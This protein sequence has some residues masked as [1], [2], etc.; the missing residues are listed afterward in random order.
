MELVSTSHQSQVAPVGFADVAGKAQQRK[1]FGS[2]FKLR[3]EQVRERSAYAGHHKALKRGETWTQNADGNLKFIVKLVERPRACVCGCC[4]WV[5]FL[6]LLGLGVFYSIFVDITNPE[7]ASRNIDL[8]STIVKDLL[9]VEQATRAVNDARQLLLPP[10][11]PSPQQSD[12]WS[13]FTVAYEATADDCFTKAGLEKMYKLENAVV[14]APGYADYCLKSGGGASSCDQILSATNVFYAS[15][16]D[17]AAVDAVTSALSTPAIRAK[18]NDD[19]Q[20]SCLQDATCAP[21]DGQIWGI[22]QHFDRNGTLN[23]NP[24]K[25]TNFIAT[26]MSTT[27]WS[28]HLAFF[29]DKSFSSAN[30]V[31]KYTR[32]RVV[33]GG[34]IAGYPDWDTWNPVFKK[35]WQE[36]CQQEV[37]SQTGIPA[38]VNEETLRMY[39]SGPDTF[40]HIQGI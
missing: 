37:M 20:T 7:T 12:H 28:P 8:T 14:R 2:A 31:T 26:L 3:Y 18:Y 36:E 23:P 5:L 4:V 29:V 17:Q 33:F 30:P 13:D 40:D 19:D 34:P 1:K 11:P 6:L 32:A 22:Y 25:V 10:V 24:D 39:Y 35:W 15:Q 38:K 9:S 27:K 16:W 21:L